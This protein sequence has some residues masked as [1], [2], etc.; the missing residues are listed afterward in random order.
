MPSPDPVADNS[1]SSALLALLLLVPAPSIGTA[2]AMSVDATQGTWIGQGVYTLSKVWL[3]AL[4]LV[5][6][7]WVDGRP[8]SWS[9][10]RKGGLLVGIGIG[11]VLSAGI[12]AAYAL[13]GAQL[14]DPATVRNRAVQVGIASPTTYLSFAV[15]LILVNSLLEEYVWR[16]FVFRKCEAALPAGRGGTAVVLSALFF[17]LH[18]VIALRAQLDWLPTIFASLGVFVG[19]VVWSWCYLKYQSVWPGYVSHVI[20]DLTLLWIGWWLIFGA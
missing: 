10:P 2:L 13:F 1:R 18:H 9:P 19:G 6:L 4:P 20:V 16:W 11:V 3:V 12:Y 5:W 17:T 8:V 15:Y 14:I 7:L